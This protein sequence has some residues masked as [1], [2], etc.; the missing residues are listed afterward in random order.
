MVAKHELGF[1]VFPLGITMG[2]D[3][4][5]WFT[6]N[7]ANAIVKLSGEDKPT[8]YKLPNAKSYPAYI[9]TGPDD[10][11]WFTEEGRD[12]IGRITPEGKIT[13]FPIPGGIGDEQ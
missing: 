12:T 10:N 1:E 9:V 4:D 5:I 8:E 13:E 11:L 6:E 2:P 3:R 7:S